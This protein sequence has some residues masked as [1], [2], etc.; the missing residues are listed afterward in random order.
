MTTQ[1]IGIVQQGQPLGQW[2]VA[3]TDDA[4]DALEQARAEARR[5]NGEQ[6]GFGESWTSVALKVES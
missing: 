4:V 3:L 1:Y 6:T 5:L 2:A